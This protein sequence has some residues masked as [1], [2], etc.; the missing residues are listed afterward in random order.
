MSL[1]A[2]RS[3]VERAIVLLGLTLVVPGTAPA[4][5]PEAKPP[6]LAVIARKAFH[7]ALADYIAHKRKQLPVELLALEQICKDQS[8]DDDAEKLKRFLYGRWKNKRVAYVLLVGDIDVLPARYRTIT[9]G[10]GKKPP[11]YVFNLTDHYYADVADQKGHFDDWNKRRDGLHRWHYAQ[12]RLDPPNPDVNTDRIHFLPELAVG[13]WPVSTPDKV[14]LIADKTI[15]YETALQSRKKPGQRR[16]ALLLWDD[17]APR[18]LVPRW[19][20]AL[21]GWSTATYDSLGRGVKP[22]TALVRDQLEQG[23]GLLLDIGH[24]EYNGWRGFKTH[25]LAQLDNADRLPIVFSVGCDTAPLGPGTLPTP[26]YRNRQGKVVSASDLKNTYPPPP[27]GVYQPELR[28]QTPM[29]FGQQMVV[30]GP[31]GAV[32]YIGFII[33]SNCWH[34]LMEGFVRAAGTRPAPRLGD[35]WKAALIYHHQTHLAIVKGNKGNFGGLHSFDQGMRVI[36]LGDPTLLLPPS[37]PPADDFRGAWMLNANGWTFTLKIEQKDDTVTGTLAGINNN[38]SG[39]IAGKVNGNRII[40]SRVG[41]GQ[42]Y[43]GYLL[44]DDPMKKANNQAVAG[45]GKVGGVSFGWYATRR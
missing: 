1:G 24:G 8:G 14:K 27:P 9:V 11:T 43:E 7:P 25:N 2:D 26:G 5:P 34:E 23:L 16:A 39:K 29:S 10:D 40:F 41:T 33:N 13:R 30:G 35:A 20:A 38:Q 17:L 15:R 4:A 42:E 22:S 45:I 37:T 12:S 28:K 21:R 31:N 44:N 19:A 36:L 3:T 32:A 6:G 18:G